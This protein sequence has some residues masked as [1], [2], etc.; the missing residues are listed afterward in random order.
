MSSR[1]FFVRYLI[2]RGA[3]VNWQS[4]T[5]STSLHL[6]CLNI[7]LGTRYGTHFADQISKTQEIAFDLIKAGA[8]LTLLDQNNK[9][10]LALLPDDKRIKFKDFFKQHIDHLIEVCGL[11]RL[12]D[13]EDKLLDRNTQKI[14]ADCWRRLGKKAQM[15]LC[16]SLGVKYPTIGNIS[17]SLEAGTTLLKNLPGYVS[18]PFSK[19]SVFF[20]QEQAVEVRLPETV[21]LEVLNMLEG[22]SGLSLLSDY[23]L[24]D[25][26]SEALEAWQLTPE[27]I[28]TILASALN[29]MPK[30]ES[31]VPTSGASASS[32]TG[33]RF[34]S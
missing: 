32:N 1:P 23:S 7:E 8:D 20:K 25:I 16:D 33:P 27:G 11:D 15:V 18:Q 5:G 17:W 13:S 4:N 2:E 29:N 19:W 21:P 28:L 3:N 6:A 9:T 24:L 14:A 31:S 12:M 30:V 22:N 26:S 34:S 10:P